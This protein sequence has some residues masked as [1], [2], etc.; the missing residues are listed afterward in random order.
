[1]RLAL[2]TAWIVTNRFIKTCFISISALENKIK[3][4]EN[5]YNDLM[6]QIRKREDFLNNMAREEEILEKT[7]F[8][9]AQDELEKEQASRKDHRVRSAKYSNYKNFP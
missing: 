3:A 1:V 9:V 2:W 6:E 4:R 7:F 8:Q 5:I